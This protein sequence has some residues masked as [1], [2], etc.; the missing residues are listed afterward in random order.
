MFLFLGFVCGCKRCWFKRILF[1][2]KVNRNE[3]G[4][5]CYITLSRPCVACRR[6]IKETT[7][8]RQRRYL[9]LHRG[10]K[11]VTGLEQCFYLLCVCGCNI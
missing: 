8:L 10:N 4:L 6:S 5:K 9:P 3:W 11:H 2:Y 1:L 7:A